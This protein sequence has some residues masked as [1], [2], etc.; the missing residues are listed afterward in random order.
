MTQTADFLKFYSE[1]GWQVFPVK[2]KDKTP[3]VKWADVATTE[4][5]MLYGWLEQYP[6][7]NIGLATGKRSGVFVLDVDAG[8]DGF[9]SLDELEKK[10]G[11][12]PKTPTVQTGGGGRHYFF[13][14]PNVEIRNVQNSGKL[15]KGLDVRGDG[16]YVVAAGSIHSSGN[17]YKWIVQPSINELADAPEW[18]VK[19]L[20]S[21][22]PTAEP[23][24]ERAAAIPNGGRN[25]TLTSLAGMM[26]R[27]GMD[28][29][30]ILNAIKIEN[31]AKCIPPLSEAEVKQIVD[32]VMRYEPSVTFEDRDRLS[33]EWAFC[34]SIYNFPTHITDFDQVTAVMF[35]DTH[36]AEFWQKIQDG[37]DLTDAAIEAGILADLER[38]ADYDISRLDG[39]ARSIQRFAHLARIEKLGD[40]LKYQ[41]RNA[42]DAGIDKV[43]NDLAKL[44]PQSGHTPSPIIEVAEDLE[45]EILERSKNP[46]DVWGIPFAWE[47]LSIQTGG[48]QKGEL[49]LTSA[50]PGLGKSWWWLQDSLFT[51]IGGNGK[52]ETP[53]F[54]W[55][56]EMRK[57]QLMNRFYQLLGVNGKNMR[58]GRMTERD[59]DL[60]SDAKALISNSPIFIDDTGLSLHEVRPLLSRMKSMYGIEQ[61]VIDYASKIRA[62]GKDEIE[63]S[64]NITKDLKQICIDLDLCGSL[65][66][67]V[68]KEGMSGQVG[69]FNV[70]GSGQQLHDADV[71]FLMSHFDGKNYGMDYGIMPQ[72]YDRVVSMRIDKGR[73]LVS[74]L[75][76]GFIPYMRDADKPNFKELLKK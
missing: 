9:Q 36:L 72:D 76:G 70:R 65:I 71:I 75:I 39:Y 59:W 6:D 43:I 27:K 7:M 24:R 46:T 12:L 37:R 42:N 41:A 22:I 58:T 38:Y 19:I 30:S 16:G 18:M 73:E 8:H 25:N 14:H 3:L 60:L 66:A 5:N 28:Y 10:Y 62:P 40:S 33:T 50:E 48:K 53:V 61:F 31:V 54:Y 2:P 47:N 4:L 13:K 32:S 34:K 55:C 23:I 64:A 67:S 68:N 49:I 17:Q 21:N 29:Q 15:G 69:K 1:K 56:G 11:S 45:A 52:S 44:P 26:R 63:Q 20:T 57:K 35:S 74:T 51:A